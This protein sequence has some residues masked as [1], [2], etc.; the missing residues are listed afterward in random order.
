M[1]TG[2]G[3]D[4][5]PVYENGAAHVVDRYAELPVASEYDEY[6]NMIPY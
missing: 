5:E 4:A 2:A 3:A 6:D 1:E